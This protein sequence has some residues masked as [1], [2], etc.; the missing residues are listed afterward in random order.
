MTCIETDNLTVTFDTRP[1][2][3]GLSLRIA[4][5]RARRSNA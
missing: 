3:R 5:A 4:R 2:W 1:L